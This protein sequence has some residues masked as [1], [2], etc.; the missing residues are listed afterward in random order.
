[1]KIANKPENHMKQHNNK[2]ERSWNQLSRI[3]RYEQQE[4]IRSFLLSHRLENYG[5]YYK[6]F[7]KLSK[8]ASYYRNKLR[9]CPINIAKNY[10][11]FDRLIVTPSLQYIT[12]QSFNEEYITLMQCFSEKM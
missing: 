8:R 12:G 2:P 11:I 9:H 7:C 3:E 4:K 6:D 5:Y 1:M 10:G